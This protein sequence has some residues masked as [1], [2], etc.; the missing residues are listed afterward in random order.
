MAFWSATESPLTDSPRQL[1]LLPW[2]KV[3]DVLDKLHGGPS[4]GHLG[5]NKTPDK[6]REQYY[7]LQAV[8]PAV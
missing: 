4:G 8:M 2:S 6:V 1:K 3:K 7:W 5:V